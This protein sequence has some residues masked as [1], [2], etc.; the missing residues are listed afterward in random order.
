V[1]LVNIEA[2]VF[3]LDGTLVDSAPTIA[4][5]IN[6]MRAERAMGMLPV[7]EYRRWVSLGATD[8]IRRSLG[9]SGSDVSFLVEDFR[10]RYRAH[11]TPVESLYPGVRDTI[12]ALSAANVLLA[13]C[14]NKPE[15][16]CQKI[17]DETA[18][19]GF[20]GS[21][22][23]GDTARFPKPARDPLDYALNEMGAQ[24]SRA[25]FVGDSTID[26]RTASACAIPFVFFTGGYDDGVDR[27]SVWE[28]INAISEV[29]RIIRTSTMPGRRLR[30]SD[31]QN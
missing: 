4:A 24:T 10:A 17:L 2:V 3:D 11:P 23:G 15:H 13:V 25:I 5:L 6:A 20:F 16:L 12:I 14:S 31:P 26:Q 22:V 7:E 28:Q 21:I 29:P 8:L 30:R 18:L 9:D 27:L 1:R 19:S